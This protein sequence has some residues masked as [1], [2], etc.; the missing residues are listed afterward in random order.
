MAG[1]SVSVT[2]PGAKPAPPC[3]PTLPAGHSAAG[4]LEPVARGLLLSFISSHAALG[5]LGGRGWHVSAPLFASLP[6][7]PGCGGH[8][9]MGMGGAGLLGTEQGLSPAAASWLTDVGLWS[10]RL[11]VR[12]SVLYRQ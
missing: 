3:F 4:G 11:S 9:P 8:G 2:G 10:V 5:R 6:L 12:L 1:E 7:W